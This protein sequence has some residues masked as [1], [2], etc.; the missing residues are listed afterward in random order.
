ME[1][2]SDKVIDKML[3][4][5][6]KDNEDFKLMKVTRLEEPILH[7][8]P[9]AEGKLVG[10]TIPDYNSDMVMLKRFICSKLY[11]IEFRE[12]IKVSEVVKYFELDNATFIKVSR[13]I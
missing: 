1:I 2:K 6:S 8:L 3:L 5:Q 7:S 12:D 9:I 11:V 13:R 10:C 4:Q